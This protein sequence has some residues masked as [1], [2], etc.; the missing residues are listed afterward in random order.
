MPFRD[1]ALRDTPPANADGYPIEIDDLEGCRVFVA[2]TVTG[3]D[4]AAPTP[5]WMARRIQLA[6]MR[7]ISLAV[8]VTNYVMLEMGHPIHGYDADKLAGTDPGPAGD[9]GRAA[10]DP[11]RRRPR[12]DRRGP[13]GHRRL[14]ARSASAA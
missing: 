13:R 7:P 1:P 3:L 10:H 11:R 5:A 2:R 12:A 4:P 9:R 6:G 8:D 14:R